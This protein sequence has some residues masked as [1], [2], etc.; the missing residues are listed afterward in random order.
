VLELLAFFVLPVGFAQQ[1]PPATPPAAI[2]H[3]DIAAPMSAGKRAL[4]DGKR[5]EA[6][7]HFRKALDYSP[8]SCELWSLLVEACADDADA[9]E[10][11]LFGLATCAV[12]QDGKLALDGEVRKRLPVEEERPLALATARAAAFDELLK[13]AAA[14]EREVASKVDNVLP[15]WW[16]RR[17]ALDLAREAP[18]LRSGRDGELNPRL[19]LP[20]SLASKVVKALDTFASSAL[21]NSRT[22]DAIKAGRILAGLGTQIAFGKDLQGE[23]PGGV[24]DL[25]E[26]ANAIL[27]KARAQLAGKSE[28]PWTLDELLAL[29]GD[30]AEAFTRAHDS[31]AN[32]GVAVSPQAWYRIETDC[33]YDTLRGVAETIELHH[34]RL[35]GWYGVDPFIG[36]PGLCR[37]VP[38]AAGLESEGAPFWWAGGFQSGDVTTLRFSVSSIEGFGHGLTHELTHRFDGAVY[39][40]MPAWLME[41]RA[42]WTGGA[43][44]G[45]Q[46]ERFVDNWASKGTIENAWIK[47]Y[48]DGNNLTKLINGTIDDY[49]DNYVAGFALYVY[50][51]TRKGAGGQPLFKA[52]LEKF[53]KEA[54]GVK[55]WRD[56]FDQCFCD[57]HDGR[58]KEFAEF[59]AAWA[60]WIAGFYWQVREKSPWTFEYTEDA[61]YVGSPLVMDEPT[62]VWSRYRAEPRFGQD[63]AAA[64]GRLLLAAG[65]RQDAIHAFLF[66]LAVD[67]RRPAEEALLAGA[68]EAESRRDAAWV[69]R[70]TIEFPYGVRVGASPFASQLPK[71][72]AWIDDLAAA[73]IAAQGAN[74]PIAAAA[75]RAERER[76]AA[77]FGA[78][79]GSA[80]AAIDATKALAGFDPPARPLGEHGFTELGLTDYEE[81]RA[82]GRWYVDEEGDLQV[83]RDKP[84][85]ATGAI[86]RGAA[87]IHCFAIAPEWILPGTWQLDARI[88]FTT[89]FVAG[90][91]IFGYSDRE[92]NLRFS[93]SAGDFMYA[94]GQSEKK[95]EFTDMGWSISGLRD[96]DGGLP[97]STSGGAFPFAAR[98]SSFT[99]TLKVDGALVEMAIDGKPVGSYHTVDG[100]AI[101]GLIGFATGMGAIEVED[102]RVTRLERSRLAPATTLPPTLFDLTTAWSLPPWQS[103]A[104]T[105]AGIERKSQGTLLL[106]LAPP[107]EALAD[108]AARGAFTSR[109][110]WDLREFA[111]LVERL[112]PT[113]QLVVALPAA[114]D[115]ADR[116]K[117]EEFGRPLIG[118]DVLFLTH[119]Q[120]FVPDG[121]AAPPSKRWL[122]FVDSAGVVRYPSEMP[123][124]LFAA[125]DRDFKQWVTVFRDHGRPKR[126]LPPVERPKVEP[127]AVEDTGND[128]HDGGG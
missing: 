13:F 4:A 120:P 37:V 17:F 128:K 107:G 2:R 115:A 53:M 35:A 67:G 24:G 36:R 38:E 8:D 63:Q 23:K 56:H 121:I 124:G 123:T 27:A 75:W 45:S 77:W 14:K 18:K 3:D 110:Q 42:V 104:R 62:W 12:L 112:E 39:P 87:Q 122:L 73:A 100:A 80:S 88:R 33:G 101:E 49:R 54:R 7:G 74:R 118:R 41:G 51:N 84:R 29:D 70:Q 93:F 94:I 106:W 99:L 90:A 31:F 113:Q 69:A 85:E 61:G 98:Q 109:L 26:R 79:A 48:G 52:R 97:F 43:F 86:D 92:A 83:G 66:A 76:A 6:A 22:A 15:A 59:V 9:R 126:D 40:G 119:Q 127:P 78:A 64:A 108:D 89:S 81:R 20:P 19:P 55:K 58:P 117:L 72:R 34:K 11:A 30:Q 96:R 103:R 5:V 71:V 1:Q 50:L 116:K 111:Q 91:V 28:K 44:G 60:P 16:A 68:L 25:R 10:L 125:D 47:G 102:A 32:P 82:K 65:K 114:L 95:P 105:C 57:G 46:S 21:A